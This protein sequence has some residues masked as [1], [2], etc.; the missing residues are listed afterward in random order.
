MKGFAYVVIAATLAVHTG[1][2]YAATKAAAKAKLKAIYAG[3][4]KV[5]IA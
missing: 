1:W 4:K 2:I 3:A 5:R